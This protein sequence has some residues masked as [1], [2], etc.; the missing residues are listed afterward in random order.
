MAKEIDFTGLDK[1]LDQI[2][3]VESLVK[4]IA[5]D[6]DGSDT[7]VDKYLDKH[8]GKVKKDKTGVD[9]TVINHATFRDEPTEPSSN[10][11]KDDFLRVVERD[12]EERYRDKVVREKEAMRLKE[13]GNVEFKAGNFE[14]AID[15]YTQG[16]AEIKTLTA[17]WTNRAQAYN[18]IGKYE[19]ALSDC[20]WALRVFE[21]CVKA[22]V[23]QGK[24]YLGLKRYNDAINSYKQVLNIDA[25]K[26]SIIKEYIA[27][28]QLA[29]KTENDD[30][31]AEEAFKTDNSEVGNVVDLLDKLNRPDQ[32][33]LYYSG[34]L[35]IITRF[36]TN[37]ND[38]TLFRTHGGLQLVQSHPAVSRSFSSHVNSLSKEDRD[39]TWACIETYTAA[40]TDNDE[41]IKQIMEESK[42]V[43][44]LQT[45]LTTKRKLLKE[46][47]IN[48]LHIVSQSELGRN[49]IISKFDIPSL[50]KSVFS[51][52]N[53]HG[54]MAVNAMGFINNLTLN[55]KYKAQLR[56]DVE[57]VFSAF[58]NF[59][60][61]CDVS[62]S[63]L[64]LCLSAVTNLTND[65]HIRQKI[66]CRKGMWDGCLH[67]LAVPCMNSSSITRHK[68]A[69][70]SLLGLAMNMSLEP[71][72]E[73][74]AA[75][76]KMASYCVELF[77]S[78]HNDLRQRSLALISHLFPKSR[79]AAET[80]YTTS[81]LE[82]LLNLLKS[83]N[84]KDVTSSMKVITVFSQQIS[85]CSL[86]IAD[87]KDGLNSVVELLNHDNE[88]IVGNAAL[89]LSNCCSVTKVCSRLAKTNIIQNLLVIVRDGRMKDVQKNAGILVAKL[90][91][92]DPRHLERLRELHGI[93]ILHSIMKHVD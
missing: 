57:N 63:T 24:A 9:R 40:C 55:P 29:E 42:Y 69:L 34:G 71:S 22:Y 76:A 12:A 65:A 14:K 18:K 67:L 59:I 21:N 86:D 15:F 41:N 25:K 79:E 80:I 8:Q 61:T 92:G 50:T 2:D 52:M 82:K 89:C 23:H 45:I 66:I 44:T 33:P 28:V 56:T 75:A 85:Q 20:D 47:C 74:K 39:V 19:E 30:L 77:N 51:L 48:F 53:S 3:T 68:E 35:R 17:L 27:E 43:G 93:E 5:S 91:Q 37:T 84:Q 90:T 83:D 49:Q 7:A 32:L 78:D 16:L 36:L 81:F 13:L 54:L 64:P 46:A 58:E 62:K 70:H 38:R 87:N 73:C 1:F 6:K 10:L 4:G 11:D 88:H 72:E 31:A 60:I 26:E